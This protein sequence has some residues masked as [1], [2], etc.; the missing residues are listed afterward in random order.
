MS[1]TNTVSELN[2]INKEIQRYRLEIKKLNERKTVLDNEIKEFLKTKDQPGLKYQ[3]VAV[4][5]E[6]GV[7]HKYKKKDEKKRDCCDVLRE[8]GIENPEDAFNK[9]V[10]SLKGEEEQ[11]TKLKIKKLN[12]K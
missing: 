10:E 2:K 8:Y 1:I 5:L 7:K 9:I 12:N 6:D 3:G 4:I 11:T